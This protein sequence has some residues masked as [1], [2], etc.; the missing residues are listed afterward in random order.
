MDDYEPLLVE[1]T[2]IKSSESESIRPI[3]VY[4]ALQAERLPNEVQFSLD[5]AKFSKVSHC[6]LYVSNKLSV[7]KFLKIL[8]VT[9]VMLRFSDANGARGAYDLDDGTG[10]IYGS[11]SNKA[12]QDYSTFSAM[13]QQLYVVMLNYNMIQI[14]NLIIIVTTV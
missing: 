2:V 4:Q 7:F 5:G 9:H 12:G 6:F 1:T 14:S 8:L 10:R 3:T 13:I 11:R